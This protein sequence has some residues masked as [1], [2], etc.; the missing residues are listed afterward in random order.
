VAHAGNLSGIISAMDQANVVCWGQCRGTAASLRS[1]ALFT[2]IQPA[3]ELFQNG[4][5]A[6]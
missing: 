3:A 6:G 2:D 5:C 1:M 4:H